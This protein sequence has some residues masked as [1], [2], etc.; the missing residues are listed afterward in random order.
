[1]GNSGAEGPLS[2]YSITALNAVGS[3]DRQSM[4]RGGQVETGI[5]FARGSVV[6]IPG[7][8][9]RVA[10]DHH[11]P[12]DRSVGLRQFFNHLDLLKCG[13]FRTAPALWHGEPEHAC[14]ADTLGHLGRKFA[15]RLDLR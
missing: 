11:A 14:A 4:T 5:Q 9:A 15:G 8:Q 1:M 3:P 10:S 12:S 13:E 7:K 2:I 6:Q